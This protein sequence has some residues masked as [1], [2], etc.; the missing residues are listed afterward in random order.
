MKYRL[1]NDGGGVIVDRTH[2]VFSGDLHVI[3]DGA[4]SGAIAIFDFQNESCYRDI[5]EG[6][7][8]VPERLF[9]RDVNV[10][11]VLYDGTVSPRTWMCEPIRIEGLSDGSFIAYPNDDNLPEAVSRLKIENDDLK[12]EFSQL[13]KNFEMLEKKLSDLMEG[14][15]II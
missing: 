14:Y 12:R 10:R 4:P 9:T 15:N 8:F 5:S 3:F 7:C 13:R 6:E 11:V 1:L 2:T